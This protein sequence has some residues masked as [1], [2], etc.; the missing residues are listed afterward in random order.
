MNEIKIMNKMNKWTITCNGGT[1][2]EWNGYT[3]VSSTRSWYRWWV[4]QGQPAPSKDKFEYFN[5]AVKACE[6]AFKSGQTQAV[7]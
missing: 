3:I 2:A 5:D 1:K 7:S 4:I 6:L